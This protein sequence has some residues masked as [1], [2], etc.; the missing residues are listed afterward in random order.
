MV[1]GLR[2][3]SART[4]KKLTETWS[5]RESSLGEEMS[6]KMVIMRQPS[7]PALC[8]AAQDCSCSED[9][10]QDQPLLTVQNLC[11]VISNKGS[12]GGGQR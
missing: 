10:Q 2:E 1:P 3:V 7:L 5:M 8:V 12:V 6:M 11:V 9:Q 4:V